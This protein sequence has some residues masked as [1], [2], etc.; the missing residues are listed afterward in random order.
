MADHGRPYSCPANSPRNSHFL[1]NALS[2]EDRGADPIPRS[3]GPASHASAHR[4]LY[5]APIRSSAEM[6]TENYPLNGELEEIIEKMGD[7]RDTVEEILDDLTE[8]EEAQRMYRSRDAYDAPS[9]M[10]GNGE[11]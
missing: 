10:D 3:S 11:E 2:P 9:Y 5:K 8:I 4:Q 7:V 6:T 1:P